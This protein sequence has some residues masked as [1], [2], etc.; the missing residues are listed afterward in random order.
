[1]LR[2]HLRFLIAGLSATAIVLVVLVA[3]GLIP[4][5]NQGAKQFPAEGGLDATPNAGA[6]TI[7]MPRRTEPSVV[8]SWQILAK[9]TPAQAVHAAMLPGGQVLLTTGS[10]NDPVRFA[11][12]TF[13]TTLWDP[14]TGGFRD[15]PTASDIFCGGQALLA[16]GT[17][18]VAGGTSGYHTKKRDFLGDKKAYIFDSK[19][20]L[21]TPVPDMAQARWYPTLVTLASGKVAAVGGFTERGKVNDFQEMYDPKSATW[22]PLPDHLFPTYP[23]LVPLA[24]GKRVFYSGENGGKGFPSPGIWNLETGA[25]SEVGG[26]PNL[27]SRVDGSTILLPPAQDQRVWT[28]GGGD[29]A[30]HPAMADSFV[31]DL[32]ATAPHYLPGPSMLQGKVF[33]SAVILPD[34][35]V[36]ESG[37]STFY[38]DSPVLEASIFNPSRGFMSQVATPKVPRVYHSTA[39]LLTDG[40]VATLGG[41]PTGL[42]AEQRIEIYSPP[43]L[44]KGERPSITQAPVEVSYTKSYPIKATAATG[45]TL[46]SFVLVRPSTTTHQNDTGQRLVDLSFTPGPNGGAITFDQGP[47]I[48]PAGWYM[49]FALD[50]VGRPSIA[51]WIHLT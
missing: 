21:F 18:L 4:G 47:G 8:G 24:D 26:L 1:M 45:S 7:L 48:A 41:N 3:A 13:T 35:T 39:L 36:L 33:V 43:Y 34:R 37:G 20:R 14:A 42:P 31:V 28:L 2:Q 5:G 38:N 25:F 17:L 19:S 30:H 51:R 32:K 29:Y 22:S 44:F 11:A 50:S 6:T 16:D 49:L 9:R 15:I 27:G 46:T 12:G 23:H 10:G 40:R